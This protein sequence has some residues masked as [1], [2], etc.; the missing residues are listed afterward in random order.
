[1]LKKLIYVILYKAV[2]I[3]SCTK[4]MLHEI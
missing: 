1:V 3:T 4:C 2:K